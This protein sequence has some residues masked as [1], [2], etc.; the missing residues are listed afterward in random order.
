MAEFWDFL[1]QL[2]HPESIIHYGGIVLL[3][4]VVFAE[5][6]LF[7]GFFLPGDSLLFTAGLLCGTGMFDVHIL[8]LLLSV[9]AAGILGNIVGYY[10]GKHTGTALFKR[11]DS[12]LFK[13]RYVHMAQDFYH[14]HGGLALIAG[15]FLPIIRTFAP[16]LAGV[17]KMDVKIFMLYNVSGSVLWVFSLIL[18][19]YFLG[20]TVPQVKDYLEY[21]IIALIIVTAIPVYRSYRAEKK[22]FT[23]S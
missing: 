18:L 7:F 14:R 3:L 16:I 12:L 5:T 22:R 13:K 10:F 9:S 19:G 11:D 17:I 2:V 4:A 23:N 15:R 20:T 1:K 6:G 8:V 21:I